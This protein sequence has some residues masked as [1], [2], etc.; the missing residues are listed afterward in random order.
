MATISSIGIGS[1][2]DVNSIITQ[3]VALQKKPLT[4]L[5]TAATKIDTQIST[6]GQIKSLVSTLSDAA[7]KLTLDSTWNAKKVTSS[8]D[9]SVTASITGVASAGA[10]SVGVSQLARAQSASSAS[11]AAKS[12]FGAGTLSIQLGTWSADSSGAPSSF[13]EGAAAA[14]S[15]KVTASDTLTS[16][17]S[18]INGSGAGVTATVMT[19][20]GGERL[21]LRSSAMG[22]ASGFRVQ[23]SGDSALSA[24]A[25]D[26]E[27]APSTGMAADLSSYQSARDAKITINGVSLSSATNT[28]DNAIAGMTF[29][30]SKVTTTDAEIKVSDDTGTITSNIQAFVDAYNAVN[31]LLSTSTKYDAD[32]K[33]A[34]ILQG[35]STSVGLMNSLRNLVTGQTGNSVF[36]RLSDLGVQMLRGG[37]LQVDGAKLTT[38]FKDMDNL[39]AAFVSKDATSGLR[40][41]GIAGQMKAFATNLL[42]FS[43]GLSSKADALEAA[44]DRNQ[45]EQDKVNARA[46]ALEDRLRTQYSALDTKMASLT[47]LNT[48]ITQQ[49]T[50]WNSS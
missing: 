32:T 44:S 2:L 11:H 21:M 28:F 5:T 1:G 13:A 6:Y 39:K 46:T 10:F 27:G 7:S 3:M 48:Y 42:G 34:G 22:A 36:K 20:S 49:V 37:N 15:V 17:A 40:T 43:G 4:A 8:D 30:A 18:K 23:A 12:T 33:T 19:D 45:A 24:L 38:A 35:D 25:F 29:T 9:T 41:G 16:I 50:K 14:I 26:P 31:G 47:A